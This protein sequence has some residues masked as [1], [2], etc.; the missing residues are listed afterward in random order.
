MSTDYYLTCENCKEHSNVS[1]ARYA[2]DSWGNCWPSNT[3]NFLINHTRSCGEENIRI[4]SE[5]YIHDCKWDKE[6][7]GYKLRGFI[8][9][10]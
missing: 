2:W 8:D 4:K 7:C 9:D 6:K 1:Y 10:L 5:H 3:F